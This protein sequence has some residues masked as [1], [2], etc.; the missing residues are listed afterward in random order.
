MFFGNSKYF[1]CKRGFQRFKGSRKKVKTPN[2][3]EILAFSMLLIVFAADS[4]YN[5][6]GEWACD[7]L[8][9]LIAVLGLIEDFLNG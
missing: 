3:A 7:N 9:G 4:R 5:S 8:A 6:Q 2:L 1:L